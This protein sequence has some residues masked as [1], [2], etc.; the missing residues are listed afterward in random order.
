MELNKNKL[1]FGVIGS[2][3]LLSFIFLLVTITN[4]N[5]TVTKTGGSGN[6][7]K[8]WT[9]G[10]PMENSFQFV[11]DFKKAYPEHKNKEIIIEN[12]PSYEDY[13]YT[14]M[15]AISSGKGPDIFI[16]NNN[17]K[18][19]VFSNQILAIDPAIVN[20]NDFR[21]RYK[22]FFSDDLISTFSDDTGTKEYLIGLPVGYETLGVFY[23]RRYAKNSDL[24][25]LSSLNNII[26]DL[27]TKYTDLIPIGIGNGSTVYKSEDIITQFFML[28][29]GVAGVGNL[30]NNVLK[31]GLSS[32]L[33]YGDTTGYNGFNS[34]FQELKNTKKDS[35]YLFSR[36]EVLM[37]VGYPS[38]I[39]NIKESG[40]SKTMLQAT[41]FPHYFSGG[42]KTL[43]DYNYFTINKDTSDIS[44]AETFMSYLYS[45]A[46]ATA[47]LGYFPYQLPALLSLESDKLQQK[48]DPDYTVILGDFYNEEYEIGSFDKGVKNIY[49]KNISLLLDSTVVDEAMFARFKET[50][51]CKANKILTF[52]NLGVNCD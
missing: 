5:N 13:T 4:K 40:F 14:M 11:D 43:A 46:G 17:E 33:L 31:A 19:S 18:N 1:I 45:D 51:I 20:P 42:G 29:G 22:G 7:F 49:D 27:S 16:L 12:F 48:I 41:P 28:E 15:A 38:M 35:I 23:N 37:V 6:T 34:R 24:K 26:S 30:N 36:G 44:L 47:Y 10:Y 9:Y 32:Y 39:K 50:I 8:I 2:L 25:N 3:I 52:A 21:K